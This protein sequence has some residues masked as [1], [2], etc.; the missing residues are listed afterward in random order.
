MWDTERQVVLI[1][2]SEEEMELSL[3]KTDRDAAQYVL[4]LEHEVMLKK[5]EE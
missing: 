5:R 4:K 2:R 3:K 1:R